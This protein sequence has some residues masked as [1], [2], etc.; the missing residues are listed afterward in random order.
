M[1]PIPVQAL[2]SALLVSPYPSIKVRGKRIIYNSLTH[3]LLSVM[4]LMFNKK[5]SFRTYLK[6][7]DGWLDFTIGFQTEDQGVF[8]AAVFRQGRMSVLNRIPEDA[9]AVLAFRDE[10]ALMEMLRV[11][12]N[13]VLNLILKNRM[14]L[15][16]NLTCLQLFNYL[17]S[18]LVGSKHQKMLDKGN[19][20]DI[21][22][23]KEMYDQANPALSAELLARRH[24]RM[25]A[26]QIDSGVVY[27]EDPYLSD[28]CL[29]DFPRMKEF[30]ELYFNIKPEIC[31]ERAELLTDWH[32]ANGFET[33]TNGKPWNHQL[34]Q[35]ISFCHVMKHKKPIIRTNDLIAGTT[36]TQDTIGVVIYPDAQGTMVWGELGSIE[37][38]LLNPYAISQAA[39]SKLH[40]DIFPFWMNRNFREWVRTKHH[41]PLCQ[42]IEERWVAYFVWKSVG[43][44]HTI[45]DF[46][47]LLEKGTSGVIREIDEA[48]AAMGDDLESGIPLV[49]MRLSLEGL[50]AYAEN[51]ARE[52]GQEMA[53]E[54][55]PLRRSELERLATICRNVPRHPARTLDEAANVLNMVW[56]ALNMENANTG[57]SFGRLDQVLQPYYLHDMARLE[58]E[59]EKQNY[60]RHAIELIGCLFLRFSDHLPLS[61]DIGNYLFGGAS[62]T[63]ALTV[64]GV[65]RDGKDAVNDMTYIMIKAVEMLG[66]RDVNLNARFHPEVNSEA[67]LTRLCEVNVITAGTPSLHNDRAVFKSLAQHGYPIEDIRDW[68]ATGCV[69][70]TIS[71]KHMGH[72]G[73]ILFNL[74]APLEM[75]LND[76]AHPLMGWKVGPATGRIEAGDF[77]TFDDFFSAFEIQLRFMI[78]Q[79]VTFNNMLAQIHAEYRPTPF[80]SASMQGAVSNARDVTQGGAV[81]NSSGTSNIGL[82]D[83]IDSLVAVKHLVY[84]TKKVT[85]RTMK[86]AID[87]NFANDPTLLTLISRHSPKFGSG[88]SQAMD[89]ACRVTQL[90]HDIHKSHTNFRGGHYTTGFWSMS[91][92][93]AYGSLSGALPS[94][95]LRG[96]AFT[97]GLTPHP[98]ASRNFLDNLRDVAG[99]DPMNMDNNIAFNVKLNLNPSE[100]REKSVDIMAS[101]VKAY[102]NMG[103][104]QLQF[105]MVTSRTLK[106]AMANPENYKHLMVRISGYNAYFVTLNRD[107]QIELV[108]RA[109]YEISDG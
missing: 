13:E 40:H 46:L 22:S 36:T 17:V 71:G 102:F 16:G 33:D 60:I 43:V 85:F 44:S 35:A 27:L 45:P 69:E 55:S 72:T 93:V 67:F 81:Y 42:R 37:K 6:S 30:H 1:P 49:A 38:R 106:D 78:G 97:P 9:D 51:L 74:V 2:L 39:V 103:G 101:Y 89:M 90:I 99:L 20:K 94:G 87:T 10:Q 64:G 48:L 41:H 107:I 53:G 54:A 58:T 68:S 104:M 7:V 12:P 26:S 23:R 105:N 4:A 108:E 31:C 76:G 88:D 25:K 50:E 21:R 83:V 98:S 77:R 96:K 59:R 52:A 91:Q 109:E 8:Q 57:L 92:H 56:I 28:V 47:T 100:S 65:T 18:L 11:T 79:A 24:V 62:S 95:R 86:Q 19:L 82:S 75:A 14:V 5:S 15:K 29:E 73:S 80:L 3:G 70:P 32:R 61:P 63:Q 66:L 34:R 84:D